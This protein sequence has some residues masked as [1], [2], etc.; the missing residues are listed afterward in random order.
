[1]LTMAADA[2]HAIQD[3][4]LDDRTDAAAKQELPES[5]KYTP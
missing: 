4:P 2:V 5:P 3:F 1:M